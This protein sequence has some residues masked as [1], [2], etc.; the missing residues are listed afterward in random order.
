MS[1]MPPTKPRRS[2]NARINA[3]KAN[4]AEIAAHAAERA[5]GL[6]A[7]EH[8]VTEREYDVKTREINAATREQAVAKAE[9]EL[10]AARDAHTKQLLDDGADLLA[11]KDELAN[12]RASFIE[13]VAQTKAEREASDEEADLRIANASAA[14][15]KRALELKARE[16]AVSA[17]EE[18]L[19][20]AKAEYDA[21]VKSLNS[22][23]S[24]AKKL[25]PAAG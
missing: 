10:K 17:G 2:A 14:L 6:E 22:A 21:T 24:T 11:Q 16:D 19:A 7:K 4:E 23:L 15:D 20:D 8:A 18:A 5:L 1:S 3:A 12:A 9:A 25:K 13:R